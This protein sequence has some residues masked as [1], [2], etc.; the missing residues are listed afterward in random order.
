MNFLKVF[1][2]P[3]PGIL[4]R[5]RDNLR[6]CIPILSLNASTATW[7]GARSTD[8][9]QFSRFQGCGVT[10][11]YVCNTSRSPL[12]PA[13][14][15]VNMRWAGI[16]PFILKRAT[17]N[18][19]WVILPHVSIKLGIGSH[20]FFCV[21]MS[22]NNKSLCAGIRSLSTIM[23]AQKWFFRSSQVVKGIFTLIDRH[24][25]LVRNF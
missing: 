11:I 23:T 14:W 5:L 21:S 22:I 7:W 1:G 2:V 4:V 12:S 17:L 3:T 24:L 8:L 10:V 9:Q 16:V 13:T 18:F 15:G 6:A 25:N 20:L 19:K